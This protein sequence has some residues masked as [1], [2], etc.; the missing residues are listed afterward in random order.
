MTDIDFDDLDPPE[1][2]NSHLPP[3][4]DYTLLEL[5][6]EGE[7]HNASLLTVAATCYRMGVSFADTLAH[8]QECYATDRIDYDTAPKRAVERVWAAEGDLSKLSE[9]EGESLPDLKDEMLLRFRRMPV[10]D[11]LD[12]SPEK[13]SVP[14][15]QIVKSLFDETDIVNIQIKST[16]FGTLVKVLDLEAFLEKH[17][18][19]LERF[20]FLNPATFKKVEGVPNTKDGGKLSTRCND[21]VKSRDWMVLEMDSRDESMVERFNAFAMEMAN[22]AP[23]SMVVDTGN[24][25]LH[26]WFNAKKVKPRIKKEFFNIA[27][28]HGADKRMAVKSQIARMPNTPAAEEGRGAQR[29]VYYDPDGKAWPKPGD[30]S[31]WNLKEFEETIKHAKQLDYYYYPAGSFAYWTRDNSERWIKLTQGSLMNHLALVGI[32]KT[33]LEGEVLSPAE[34]KMVEIQKYR[35]LEAVMRG[36]SGRHAGYYEENG[37]RFLV[38]KSPV[39]VKARKREFPRIAEFVGA[40]LGNDEL[41]IAVFLGWLR[42]AMLDLRND[43]KRR[44]K[45]TPA[46]MLHLIGAPN[47]GKTLILNLIIKNC[48]GGRSASADPLFR[49]HAAEHNAEMFEAELLVLDD[50]PVLEANYH[51]RQMFGERIKTFTVGM[52]GA[53]RGMHQDRITAPPWWRFVRCMNNEPQTLATLPPLDEGV[54][55]KLIF[56]LTTPLSDWCVEHE[57]PGW[58]D[59]MKFAIEDELPGFI[60]YLLEE[61]ELPKEAK[62]PKNRYPVISY[63]HP[64]ITDEIHEGSPEHYIMYRFEGDL[65]HVMFGELLTDGEE[66]SDWKGSSDELYEILLNTGTRTQQNRF[67]KVVPSPKIFLTLL[68]N[69][70]KTTDK[71]IYSQRSPDHPNKINGKYYWIVSPPD[72]RIDAEEFDN[73]TLEE[74]L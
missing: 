50:S 30:C 28:I 32:R 37:Q 9:S 2:E 21:N 38:Q 31:T 60:H 64:N 29:V 49:L 8:L 17:N 33:L 7:G 12:V 52:G 23:L 74:M 51:F 61:F 46:Q 25:S 58:Y 5:K 40:F 20:K 14:A 63:K 6:P 73:K 55:D 19:P 26:Y 22:F 15:L 56:L 71:V 10:R 24:K 42:Q 36:A 59:K 11:I 35:G 27:C 39:I 67:L 72:R 1:N 45:F 41:Q 62:D 43:G 18:A 4:K 68:R 34:L 53:Y 65:R 57:I 48:L 13:V 54:E 66:E 44:G 69:L 70:E 47:S 3:N 16:H